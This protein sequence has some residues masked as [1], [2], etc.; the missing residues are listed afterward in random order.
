M[1]KDLWPAA[2]QVGVIYPPMLNLCGLGEK[3][4][5]G[6]KR[7]APS[8]RHSAQTEKIPPWS[9]RSFAR[10]LDKWFGLG[11][12]VLGFDLEDAV[13]GWRDREGQCVARLHVLAVADPPWYFGTAAYPPDAVI[14][15]VPDDV[16]ANGGLIFYVG[17]PGST[18][19]LLPPAYR[20]QARQ[21]VTDT[22]LVVYGR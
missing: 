9:F 4:R 11:L 13:V 6:F 1:K 8:E 17:D 7:F 15:A 18:P 16:V 22:C 5:D 14:Q 3:R 21:C 10:S 20:E 12:M 2:A 19:A